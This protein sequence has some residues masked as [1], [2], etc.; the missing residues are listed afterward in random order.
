M[1]LTFLLDRKLAEEFDTE[2]G[3]SFGPDKYGPFDSGVYDATTLLENEGLILIREPDA[4][5][6]PYETIQYTLTDAGAD[7][8]AELYSTLPDGQQELVRWIKQKYGFQTLGR[9]LTYV[10]NQYP[11]MTSESV[12]K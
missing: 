5:D 12:L 8:A 6:G 9:L 10:Y 4:H 1:K 3:F 11:S 7:R 2:T